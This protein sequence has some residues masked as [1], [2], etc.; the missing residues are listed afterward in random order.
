MVPNIDVGL[1][2]NVKESQATNS[3]PPQPLLD[4]VSCLL[5]LTICAVMMK[6]T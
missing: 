2:F 5:I 4:V 1:S 3:S 6:N